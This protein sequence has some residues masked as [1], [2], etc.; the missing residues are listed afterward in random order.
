MVVIE[1]MAPMMELYIDEAFA[2]LTGD[3]GDVWEWI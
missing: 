3:V 2:E 1:Q